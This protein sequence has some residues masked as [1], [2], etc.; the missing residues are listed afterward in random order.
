[1]YSKILSYN[2]VIV[3]AALI[4]QFLSPAFVNSRVLSISSFNK[5]FEEVLDHFGKRLVGK[6]TGI[7][8]DGCKTVVAFAHTV[9]AFEKNEEAV[10]ALITKACEKLKIQDTRICKGIVKMFQ[11]E[12]LTVVDD[13]FINPDEVCGKLLGPSCAH[14]RNPSAFWNITLP[15]TPKPPGKPFLPP[16]VV[17]ISIFF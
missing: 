13:V 4:L 2:A 12:V 10:V 9:F 5:E 11:A 17:F 14:Y 6:Q 7:V 16:K 15:K 1:M 3:L 8:C